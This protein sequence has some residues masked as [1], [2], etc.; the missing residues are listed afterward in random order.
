MWEYQH[1]SGN[2]FTLAKKVY[3]I[4]TFGDSSDT[5][6]SEWLTETFKQ[7]KLSMVTGD[8]GMTSDVHLHLH[9]FCKAF[10]PILLIL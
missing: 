8:D 2:S 1:Y 7:F 4:Q 6:S 10:I 9:W 3:N 5:F